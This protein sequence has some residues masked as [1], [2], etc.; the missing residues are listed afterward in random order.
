[1]KI[2]NNNEILEATLSELQTLWKKN[3]WDQDYTFDKYV[4]IQTRHNGVKIKKS[5]GRK[6]VSIEEDLAE[7]SRKEKEI[8]QTKPEL[9]KLKR[10]LS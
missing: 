1:M 7:I 5:S 10:L 4:E 2:G 8:S 3:G 9:R 6:S